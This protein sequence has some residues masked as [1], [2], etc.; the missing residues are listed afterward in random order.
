MD[1]TNRQRLYEKLGWE[2]L[3]YRRCYRRLCHFF[4][5]VK[6]RSSGYLFDEIPLEHQVSYSLRNVRD[7][8]IHA[9]GTNRF[10]NTYFYNT[11][12]EWNLLEEE[13]KNS[14]SLFQFKSKLLKLIRPQKK[15][16]YNICDID[17]ARY[18]T[19]LRLKFSTPNEHGFR[20]NFDSPT[21]FCA[22][23][24]DKE[25]NEHF[26]L[27]CPQF[28]LMHQNLFGQ[29]SDT[30]GLILNLDDKSLCDLL[31]F[32]DSKYSVANNRKILEA[33]ISFIKNTKRFSD[34]N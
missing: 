31:L 30:P 21:P 27:H 24:I 29:L 5:L 26:F 25:D 12:S 4:K 33:T 16:T 6:S 22:C 13:I 11:L 2:S 23:G 20:N 32:G 1:G 28:Y 15:S 9:P 19:K 10:S 17:G 14:V 18:L 34:T 3:Y 7:Y 8:E